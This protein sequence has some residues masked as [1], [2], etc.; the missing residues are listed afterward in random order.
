MRHQTKAYINWL[1]NYD[2]W[3]K[4]FE[5][6]DVLCIS[7]AVC[8]VQINPDRWEAEQNNRLP[9]KKMNE[10]NLSIFMSDNAIKK[11]DIEMETMLSWTYI[12]CASELQLLVKY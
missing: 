3:E 2:V 10:K 11:F 8:V 5:S 6:F 7:M 1:F 9:G 12:D 4:Q